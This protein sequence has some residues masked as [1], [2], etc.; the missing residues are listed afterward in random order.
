M[1]LITQDYKDQIKTMQD[2]FNRGSVML[3]KLDLFLKKYNPTSLIDFGC[4]QGALHKALGNTIPTVAGYDPGVP[5]FEELPNST[6]E[7]LVSIDVLEHVEPE[8]L[9]ETLRVIDSLFTKACY[10][11]IASYPAKKTL[12]DGRNA[13][14]IIESVDW[15]TEKITSN[16]NGSI[17]SVVSVPVE[18]KTKKGEPRSGFEFTFI[19]EKV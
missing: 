7:T 18:N 15:W 14:L 9:E 6:F 19:V 10:L 2:P 8:K 1:S 5:E 4:S 17:V 11:L 3:Y 12:P 13:H 16:I